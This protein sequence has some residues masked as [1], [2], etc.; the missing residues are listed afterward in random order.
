[1]VGDGRPPL[2]MVGVGWDEL[3]MILGLRFAPVGLGR[4]ESHKFRNYVGH[5]Y[6]VWDEI[7]LHGLNRSIL[8]V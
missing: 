6:M 2:D 4:W 3:N 1:M 5:L 7:Y 8:D